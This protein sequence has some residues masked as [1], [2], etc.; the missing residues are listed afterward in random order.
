M[1]AISEKNIYKET[2]I[3]KNMGRETRRQSNTEG[4]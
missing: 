4:K 2:K 1:G 3:H